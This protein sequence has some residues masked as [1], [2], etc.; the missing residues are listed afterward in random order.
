[1]NQLL[2]P[3]EYEEACSGRE[4]GREGGR[5]GISGEIIVSLYR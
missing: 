3:K 2:G 5:E 4:E 1:V